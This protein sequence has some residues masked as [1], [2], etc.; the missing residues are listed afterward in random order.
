[1]GGRTSAGVIISGNHCLL[2]FSRL[3]FESGVCGKSEV[4]GGGDGSTC[5]LKLCIE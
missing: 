1:M 5:G 2:P 4:W 3:L